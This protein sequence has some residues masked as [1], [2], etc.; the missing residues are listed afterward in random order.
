MGSILYGKAMYIRDKAN[1][2]AARIKQK[3][4]NERRGAEAALGQFG[5]ALANKRALDAAGE[6]V[7]AIN[8]NVGRVLD[9]A[10]VGRLS[11]RIRASEE[12]GA[13]MARASAA[14]VGGASLEASINTAGLSDSLTATLQDRAVTTQVDQGSRAITG[15]LGNAIAGLD[16]DI[17]RAGLD[18]TQYVD[19]AKPNTFKN[20]ASIAAAAGAFV[21]GWPQ[22]A[23]A[24]IGLREAGI[25]AENGDF[26]GASRSMTGAISSGFEGFR[27]GKKNGVGAALKI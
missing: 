20:I 10:T 21:L 26:D 16:N 11:D 5:Q 23:K 18:Y 13:E 3:A 15:T 12:L 6:Q 17:I 1:V 9:R 7:T 19:P 22:A 8:E 2:D 4:S 25:A 14:G 24:V 27:F